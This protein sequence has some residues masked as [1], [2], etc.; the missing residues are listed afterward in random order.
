MKNLVRSYNVWCRPLEE[1]TPGVGEMA[2]WT[3]A[4]AL[5]ASGAK[6]SPGFESQ[7]HRMNKNEDALKDTEVFTLETRISAVSDM[8]RD[9]KVGES[10]IVK[11][12]PHKPRY[13][14]LETW[15][16]TKDV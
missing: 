7:S 2:E 12:H 8:I 11:R 1:G 5:K 13:S 3:N 6:R 14:P 15:V 10:L 9:L 4:L 16:T